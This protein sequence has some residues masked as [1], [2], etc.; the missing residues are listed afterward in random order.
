MAAAKLAGVLSVVMRPAAGVC[1]TS[2]LP[3]M[4]LAMTGVPQ[5]IDSRRT[6][7]QPSRALARTM[8][9]AAV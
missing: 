3:G 2:G 5:A 1:T 8:A 7:A 6:L 9:S 4:L